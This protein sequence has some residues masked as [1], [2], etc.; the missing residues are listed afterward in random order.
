[1]RAG[2]LV[3]IGAPSDLLRAPADAGIAA[4]F[5]TPRRQARI[6]EERLGDLA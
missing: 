1:M 3:Q 5:D 6:L 4:L 2:H